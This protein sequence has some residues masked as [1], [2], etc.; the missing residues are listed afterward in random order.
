MQV[1]TGGFFGEGQEKVNSFAALELPASPQ[2][3]LSTS[4]V[5]EELSP[6]SAKPDAGTQHIASVSVSPIHRHAAVR[7]ED[8][9]SHL[10]QRHAA[11]YWWQASSLAKFI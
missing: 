5:F 9:R 4:G 6:P 2:T 3:G 8:T 1:W 7:I 10:G 11:K